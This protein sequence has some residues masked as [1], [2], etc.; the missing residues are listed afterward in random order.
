MSNET[1]DQL[2]LVSGF[3][4]TGKSASLRNIRNQERWLYNNTEA[5]K[6]LPFANKFLNKRISDPYEVLGYFDQA[7]ENKDKLDGIITD[8]ITFLMEMYESK[9]VLGSND[10]QKAWGNFAQYFKELMQDKV[11][12]WG[13]P[14]IFTAHL[15]DKLDTVKHEMKTEVPI[16]GALKNNG[17]E[18]YFSTVV[19]TKRVSLLELEKYG[20]DLLTITDEDRELGFKHVFQTRITKETTGE[21]IRA[22]MG[23]F[24]REQTYI[25]NDCQLLLDHLTK[26]Y[27]G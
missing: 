10:T 1:N 22:P 3:S 8:S 20:S 16:K 26:F 2:V 25:D 14:T 4:G 6:R 15:L 21:R 5:G 9:Y 24:T 12:L 27:A 7:I 19:S 18:A 17:I 13:K 11:V 23:M